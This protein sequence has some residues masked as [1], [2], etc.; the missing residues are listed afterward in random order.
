MDAWRW[1]RF[2]LETSPR[3]SSEQLELVR[4]LLESLRTWSRSHNRWVRRPVQADQN[5][6]FFLSSSSIGTS[7]GSFLYLDTYGRKQ[8]DTARVISPVFAPTT[9]GLCQFRF[10]YHMYGYNIASLNIYQRNFVGGP[11]KFLVGL[12]GQRGDEWLRT[13][14]N[15]TSTEP[16][17]ILI[18]GVR[19]SGFAGKTVH[20][21]QTW[22]ERKQTGCSTI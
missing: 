14:V 2:P 16:F 9:S 18:E 10:W 1:R 15:L 3:R 21:R 7:K 8:N 22:S 20:V 13:K 17:Q 12:A 6:Y 4:W 11:R 19:N 5:V